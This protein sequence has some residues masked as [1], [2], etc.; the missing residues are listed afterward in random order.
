MNYPEALEALSAREPQTIRPGLD[1]I[2]AILAALGNPEERFKI[3]HVAGTN[4]KGS[5]SAMVAAILE[6]AGF[7]VGLYT[8]PHLSSVRERIRVNRRPISESEFA[9]GIER[10]APL[11]RLHQPTYFETLTALGL[12]HFA[13]QGVDWAVLEVGMG[14]RW[15]ATSVGRPLV[16]VITP[17]DFDHQAYLGWRL[18]E[19]AGEKAAIIRSG[20]AV[21]AT[22]AGAVAA[23]LEARARDAGVPLLTEE[24][25]L[26]VSVRKQNLDGFRLDLRGR[27]WALTDCFVPLLGVFQPRNA[28]LAVGAVGALRTQGFALPDGAIREGLGSVRWPGRFQPLEREPWLI[29]DSAH[30]PAGA[31]A[32][33]DSLKGYFP[34]SQPTLIL[35]IYKDKDKGEILEILA[36]LATRLILTTSRNPRAASP[37]ELGGMLPN[38][39]AEVHVISNI[40]DSLSFALAQGRTAVT[41]V[42]G[43]LSLVAEAIEW[44]RGEGGDIPCEI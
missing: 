43:S 21:S 36:P 23:V 18:E 41:C 19:I 3:V 38:T 5:V 4:G 20:V 1:R 22:Q 25:E 13:S 31:R 15:D 28:L 44:F 12:D 27:D 11:I 17:I 39:Q 30:N 42:A 24:R 35:G 34:E 14:G 9:R 33:A 8:S 26:H 37:M 10:L 7:R 29:V 16:S 2:L 6:A 32:L 40:S